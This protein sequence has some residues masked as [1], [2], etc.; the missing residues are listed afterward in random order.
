MIDYKIISTGSAGNAVVI[1]NVILIDCGVSFKAIKDVY[2][3]IKLVLLTHI[4][5]DH[6]NKTT[7]RRLAQE[8]PTL[9]FAC[10]DYLVRDVVDCGVNKSNIDVLRCDYTYNYGLCEIIPISLVHN[11]PNC[12]YKL[13]FKNGNKM[14]YATD[15]NNLNGIEAKNFDLYMIEANFEDA[16]IEERIR[17]KKEAGEFAYE[18]A[19]LRNHLSKAKCDDF[20]YKNIGANGVYVYMHSHREREKGNLNNEQCN[21]D[22]TA[23]K[24]S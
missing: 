24:G 13:F 11:V 12:G 8:R 4:H 1:E 18:E 2:R 6:F 7:I 22:G 5:S 21:F 10:C 9:R 15:T 19:V 20:I 23:R 14:I 16:E 17:A 3:G